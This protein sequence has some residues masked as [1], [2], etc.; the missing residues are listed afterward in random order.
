MLVCIETFLQSFYYSPTRVCDECVMSLSLY[1]SLLFSGSSRRL[2]AKRHTR[3]KGATRLNGKIS[4]LSYAVKVVYF[5]IVLLTCSL[6]QG[7]G[8][9]VGPV[10]F[11]GPNGGTVR[12][13]QSEMSVNSLSLL[14]VCSSLTV[15]ICLQGPRGVKGN[16]GETVSLP[17]L[18]LLSLFLHFCFCFLCEIL[19]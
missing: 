3:T 2:W 4:D 13:M 15:Y 12:I 19:I 11:I 14:L 1:L 16:R 8:G 6:H 17:D 10:G 7:R 9:V 5:I 18:L